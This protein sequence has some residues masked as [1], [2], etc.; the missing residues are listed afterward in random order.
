MIM[1]RKDEN[2]SLED[3]GWVE[4]HRDLTHGDHSVQDV[5]DR[6]HSECNLSRH[7]TKKGTLTI[8]YDCH[9]WWER[10]EMGPLTSALLRRATRYSRL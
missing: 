1:G 7:T 3:M 4:T 8:D 5:Y 2:T 9:L 6:L 10:Y